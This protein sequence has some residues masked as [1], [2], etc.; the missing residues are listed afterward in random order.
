MRSARRSSSSCWFANL[1]RIPGSIIALL[2][3]T[4]V[5]MMLKLPV[6]TI[7]TRF[8]GIPSGLPSFALPHFD[9]SK[10]TPLLSP[11]VTV[12]MLGAIESLLS[13]VV[14]D[15]MSGDKHNPNV[16][17]VAQGMANIV[18][19][20]FGGLPATG[21]IART[22]TNIRSG[23][24]TPVAGIVHALTLLAVLLFAAPLA[25]Y[26]PLAVL[27]A[28][29]MVVAYNMGEWKEIPKIL[30]LSWADISVWLVTFALTVFADLTL[31]VQCGMVLAALLFIRKVSLTTSVTRVTAEYVKDGHLHILQDKHI[32]EYVTV[33]RIHGPFLFGTTDQLAVVADQIESLTPIV[34]LRLRNMTAIDATGLQALEDLAEKCRAAEPH[35][36]LVRRATSAWPSSMRE[37]DF[38]RH[39]GRPTFST[40]SMRRLNARSSSDLTAAPVT[41]SPDRSIASCAIYRS[42]FPNGWMP[43]RPACS[44][45]PDQSSQGLVS[46]TNWWLGK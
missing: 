32:P 17:L 9:A 46:F 37:A 36:D 42:A 27:S 30:K 2:L 43:V 39:V 44:R 26:I 40:T 8:G 45:S 22:A 3:G 18:S 5:V 38:E 14:S 15:R 11:A 34:I 10:I 13:A 23:A 12:A 24:K 1:P 35:A 6:E 41:K 21:A 28:I 20:L 19:P 33:F 4:A 25:Q 31:A 16:E 29:L 7:G